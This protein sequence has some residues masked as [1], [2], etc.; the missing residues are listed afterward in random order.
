ML[1]CYYQVVPDEG[2]DRCKVVIEGCQINFLYRV[3]VTAMPQGHCHATPLF[4]LSHY[5]NIIF[6]IAKP[7]TSN[8]ITIYENSS[9]KYYYYYINFIWFSHKY[10]I[11]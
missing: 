7:F 4:L 3:Q 11:P 5:V 8:S 6:Q 9:N 2:N 1:N 10:V